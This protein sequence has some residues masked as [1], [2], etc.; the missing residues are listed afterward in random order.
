MAGA[1][2][3]EKGENVWVTQG[4]TDHMAIYIGDIREES[5][6]EGQLEDHVLI[7]WTTTSKKE[8]C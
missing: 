2:T 8:S 6:A 4:K 7:R 3:I 5:T 1:S